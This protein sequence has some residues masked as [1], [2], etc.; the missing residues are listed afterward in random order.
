MA[1]IL[2]RK[3]GQSITIGDKC[4]IEFEVH[5]GVV[6]LIIHAPKYIKVIRNELNKKS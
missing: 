4:V 6:K 5:G 3:T 2:T 1:L